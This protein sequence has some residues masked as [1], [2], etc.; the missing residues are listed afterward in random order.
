MGTDSIEIFLDQNNAKT[1]SYDDDD[2]QYRVNFDN[3]TSFNP[4]S[5][6]EGFESATYVDGTNY[7]VEVKIPLD[8]ITPSVGTKL[9]FDV[10][11]NDAKDG[12]RQ[13]VAA[14]NDTTG[15]GYQDPSVFGIL[16]SSRRRLRT[17]TMRTSSKTGLA[18][19]EEAAVLRL[20]IVYK[21]LMVR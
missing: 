13:S 3:E 10:Q 1:T 7:T 21:V 14:W 16:R 2:G 8:A 20:R 18:V 11:I 4:P 17:M 19:A 9:G 12:A 15:T 5:I 6:A